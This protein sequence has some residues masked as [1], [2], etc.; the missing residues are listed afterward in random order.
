MQ[1]R[2]FRR[3]MG[4]AQRILPMAGLMAWLF[5]MPVAAVAQQYGIIE[6][7]L[8]NASYVG[9][10]ATGPDGALWFAA[11]DNGTRTP[12]IGSI[13]PSGAITQYPLPTGDLPTAIA[14]GP[15]GA[16]WFTFFVNGELETIG[17]MTTSGV[18]TQYNL[19]RNT[20]CCGSA[21]SGII[22]GPHGDLWFTGPPGLGVTTTSGVV[23]QGVIFD[24]VHEIPTGPIVRGSDGALWVV[25]ANPSNL[26]ETHIDR[27][28]TQFVCSNYSALADV[29]PFWEAEGP[30]GAVWFTGY[31]GGGGCSVGRITTDGAIT[32]YPVPNTTGDRE[33]SEIAA[34][35]D[36]AL[37]FGAQGQIVRMTTSGVVTEYPLPNPNTEFL[38]LGVAQGPAG[39]WLAEVELPP[40]NSGTY[41]RLALVVP[42]TASLTAEPPAFKP[43]SNITL[44]G[45][46]FAPGETVNLLYSADIGKALPNTIT[47]DSTGSFLLTGPAGHAPFGNN[48]VSAVGQSSG[49]QGVT[50]VLVNPRLILEPSSGN[51]GDTITASGSG[52]YSGIVHFFWRNPYVELGSAPVDSLGRVTGFTFTIPAGAQ[53]G[54]Q[55][56]LASP[57][58]NPA[59]RKDDL[60]PAPNGIAGAYVNVL[61]ATPSQ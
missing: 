8:V 9:A 47:A 26:N 61:A 46:G 56:V 6:H 3:A 40:N 60:P 5:S 21:F 53:P 42:L 12:F 59:S 52:L 7:V 14:A 51:I 41:N 23:S 45:S 2:N 48:S 32:S 25:V 28:T 13:T 19:P 38:A 27:C 37:W 35:R 33:L 39:M 29:E 20:T 57:Y 4:R 34:G 11:L 15:D 49:K 55:L 1:L 31:C 50:T 30:D 24:P 58:P 18:F 16:L 54:G 10:L 44:T 36:G 17:R 43:G 22:W